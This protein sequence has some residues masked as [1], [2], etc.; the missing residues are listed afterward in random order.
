MNVVLIGSRGSGKSAVAKALATVLSRPVVST[1]A[2]IERRAGCAI[3]DFVSN[4]GWDA[5]RDLE[6]EVVR[7]VAPRADCIIDTGGGVVL[8]QAN[9]D[10]LRAGG[11]VFWLQAPVTVLAARIKDD[12]SRPSLTGSK[13]AVDELAD[14][15]AARTPLYA[16]AAH[17][18][19]DAATRTP[20]EIAAE[21]SRLFY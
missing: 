7:H 9:V 15:L 18:S 3:V 14:V 20:E 21:I 5:F 17:H 16:A 19:I 12:A 1:D 13:S 11:R 6:S 10:A 4:R 2:E 8:R